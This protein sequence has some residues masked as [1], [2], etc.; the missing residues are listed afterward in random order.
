VATSISRTTSA[1]KATATKAAKRAALTISRPEMLVNG[2]DQKFRQLVHSLLAF[3]AR[4]S[5]IREGHG[6][7]IGLAGIEYTVLISI[8][9]LAAGGDVGVRDVATHLHLSG[10]FTTTITNRLL[11]KG[12]IDKA[13]HPVDKRRLCLTVTPHGDA[14]LD[15]LA[16]TQMQVND[17][18]FDCLT[19]KEFHQLLDMVERLVKSS[20]QAFA[21]QRY[22]AET[23][24]EAEVTD[25]GEKRE[26]GR[27]VKKA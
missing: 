5:A 19:A 8:R 9:H 4:H 7:V 2:S 10:A 6:A 24:T 13:P 12:L 27:K 14:L 22:L 16:P 25:L 17:A 20:N 23:A 26:T 11:T 1:K 3:L 15:R 18:Q 21:L